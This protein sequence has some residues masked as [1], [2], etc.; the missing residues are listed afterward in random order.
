M[1]V[2]VLVYDILLTMDREVNLFWT[3][4]FSGATVLYFTVRIM[5]LLTSI[6][7][8]VPFIPVLEGDSEVR[9]Q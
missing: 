8:L 9:M 1:N 4:Y 6:L 7:G 3:G 2:A 5:G